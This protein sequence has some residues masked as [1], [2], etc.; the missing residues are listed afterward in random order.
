MAG[1]SLAFSRGWDRLIPNGREL[2]VAAALCYN[3]DRVLQ[4]LS[5][6]V[7]VYRYALVAQPVPPR[8]VLAGRRGVSIEVRQISPLEPALLGMEITSDILAFRATQR[9]LC[10]AAYKQDVM[11]GCLWFCLGPYHEDE[12]RCL[13]APVPAGTTAWDFGA[14][15]LPDHRSSL[16]FLRLWDAANAYLRDRGVRWSLSRISAYN[17]ASLRSHGSLGTIPLGVATFICCGRRQLMWSTLEPRLHVSTGT[18]DVPA[19]TV[20]A[21][22]RP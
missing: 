17:L 16:A 20:R 8:P 19:L 2:G 18:H 21:P 4:K 14:Y 1:S 7:R 11:I 13:F 22:L 3:A 6:P 15:V 5:I 10:F 12:V 9:P